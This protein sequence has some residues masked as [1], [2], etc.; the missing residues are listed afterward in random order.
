MAPEQTEHS[1][2][3]RPAA[4]VWALG[5]I[6]FY[7]L[8]GRIYWLG[9]YSE[10]ASAMTLLREVCFDP[11]VPA[12][13]RAAEY[14]VGH[15]V[16]AGFDAWFARCV[17]RES[18]ARFADASRVLEALETLETLERGEGPRP[19][20]MPRTNDVPVAAAP[21]MPAATSAPAFAASGVSH[22]PVAAKTAAMTSAPIEGAPWNALPST[23]ESRTATP[24]RTWLF[25][26]A[27]VLVV[28]VVALLVARGASKKGAD[29]SASPAE[30]AAA[31]AEPSAR[32]AIEG[33]DSIK[34][35]APAPPSARVV[36]PAPAGSA[37]P[38]FDDAL[39]QANGKIDD[40]ILSQAEACAPVE[41]SLAFQCG[42]DQSA[43][44]KVAIQRGKAIGATVT[45]SPEQPSFNACMKSRLARLSWKD[46][47][48]VSTC[49]RSW[50]SK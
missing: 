9:A 36:E 4:D 46:V 49:L 3:I 10:G 42:L 7:L 13:Q 11:I 38:S 17:V 16:P 47:P 27:G 2:K 41:S 31:L 1:S 48:G 32:R 5:L 20:V 12:S 44:V 45:T 19:P 39:K 8:T 14:G 28:G 18:E 24:Q 29:A 22:T 23:M 40:E 21:R 50:K 43:Y 30:P 6:A 35:E 15:L 37:F 25:V 34:S 26:G 33:G